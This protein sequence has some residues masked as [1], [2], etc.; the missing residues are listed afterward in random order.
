MLQN[1]TRIPI[2]MNDLSSIPD[3]SISIW[4]EY[5]ERKYMLT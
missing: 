4:I 2:T 1:N 3:L 5:Y